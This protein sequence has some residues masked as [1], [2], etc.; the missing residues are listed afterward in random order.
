MQKRW[1]VNG[2]RAK[3]R[4]QHTSV[5]LHKQIRSTETNLPRVE[6][7]TFKRPSLLAMG[8]KLYAVVY[9]AQN[10]SEKKG[11]GTGYAQCCSGVQL[12]VYGHDSSVDFS[13]S[14][15]GASVCCERITQ[16]PY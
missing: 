12:F 13:E 15:R 7:L 3:D 1:L 2:S 16:L 10:E 4:N 9:I 6:R 11:I 5:F 14:T 8:V